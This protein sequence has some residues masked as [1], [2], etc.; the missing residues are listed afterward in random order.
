MKGRPS[1]NKD[2]VLS[3]R[4]IKIIVATLLTDGW[5]EQGPKNKTPRIGLQLQEASADLLAVWTNELLPIIRKSEPTLVLKDAPVPDDPTKRTEKKYPQLYVRTVNHPQLVQFTEAFNGVGR[6]KTVPK[7]SYLLKYLDW[8]M[9]AF[10][11]M[12]D[13]SIK[14]QG[15]GME[16]H[17]QGFEGI[18]AQE[19]FCHAA[20]Q[21]LGLMCW[22]SYHK[23]LKSSSKK[24]YHIQISGFSLPD[25]RTNALPFMLK[26]YHYKVPQLGTS[27]KSMTNSP[28]P[29]WYKETQNA[30]W[31]E[32]FKAKHEPLDKAD[33]S[34]LSS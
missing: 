26:E 20:Y 30:E 31:L 5:I 32:D 3:H 29:K 15:Q 11:L 24:S 1:Y 19:R 10:M 12:M 6:A 21:N 28:W 13:G 9:F 18:E 17:L 4:Q 33:G 27:P 25:I 8:E 34:S 22:P 16:L 7:V 14:N 2:Y 23:K